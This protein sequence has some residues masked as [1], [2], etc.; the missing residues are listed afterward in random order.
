MGYQIADHAADARLRIVEAFA[1]FVKLPSSTALIK[2]LN[3]CIV[4]ALSIGF[5]MYP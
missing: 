4:I 5:I 1:A 2:A 3:L